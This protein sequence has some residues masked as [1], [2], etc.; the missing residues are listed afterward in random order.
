MAFNTGI[1]AQI[2]VV[3]N[4]VINPAIIPFLVVFFHQSV[5]TKAGPNADPNPLQA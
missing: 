3:K 2:T 1:F 5:K 4:P